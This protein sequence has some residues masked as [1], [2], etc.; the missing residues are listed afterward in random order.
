MGAVTT[1]LG[2]QA[3]SIFDDI[4][5]TVSRT[6]SGLRAEHKW[7]VVRVTVLDGDE[8]LPETGDL[9][10]FVTWSSEATTLA[11][12]LTR[13]DVEYEWAIIGVREDGDYD[14]V[15]PGTKT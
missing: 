13:M 4:G 5:Y 14:I 11:R 10:C 15:H 12:R 3:Q 6:D 1:S 8:T 9:R 2:E 7:R